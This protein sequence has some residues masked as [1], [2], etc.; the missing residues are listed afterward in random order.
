M[1]IQTDIKSKKFFQD[2]L[3]LID[4]EITK[5]LQSEYDRQSNQIE[6]IASENI[7]SLAVIQA[8]GSIMTNK[9]AE[10]YPGKRYYGGCEY[11]DVVEN[12]A[13]DRAKK[14]FNCKY[15]NVQPN[16]GS[17]ANQ[18]VMLALVK[19]HD[20]VVGMSLDAGGHLTHGAAP[21]VSGKWF[22]AVQYGVKKEDALLDYE[23][24]EKLSVENKAKIIIAGGSAYPRIIDFKR[25][26]EIADKVGAYFLVDMAHFAGC[27][28]GEQYPNPIEHAHVVTTTTHKT[29]RGPRGGMILSNDEE[30][31]KKFNSAVFPGMQGGPLMHVIAAKAV[32]YGEALQPEF[33]D[34][35]ID[36]I[37]NAKILA[38]TLIKRGLDIV[39]GGTDTHLA[40]VDLRPKK[41]TGKD[42]EASLERAG[43]TCN[44]NG[45]PFDPEK[46]WITSGI[47]L[48]TPAGTT[49]GF[50][51]K[52]FE[53]IGNLIGDVLDGLQNNLHD[54]SEIEK[55]VQSEVLDL[56]KK[57]PIY[58]KLI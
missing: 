56:C 25:I 1:S 49:R 29:L 14:I 53:K 22:N 7:A 32:A 37:K 17:Q 47:R 4:P 12:L 52:E 8:Q 6:L 57:F 9:Y 42:A 15:A 18:A 58:S 24:I 46:P 34:Y 54:N 31:G 36:V 10:G 27:V 19:P 3:E 21:N 40:L 35:I 45:V 30:L 39:S 13:I 26:R 50:K 5:A 16:S 33:K 41:L 38:S 55:K 11:Y 2:N 48:G 43:L 20:T 51:E 28:A 23:Q 44:K